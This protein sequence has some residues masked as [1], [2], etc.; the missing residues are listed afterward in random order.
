MVMTIKEVYDSYKKFIVAIYIY[1]E[2]EMVGSGTGFLLSSGHLITNF[3]IF[4]N[5][6]INL[7]NGKNCKVKLV[8]NEIAVEIH[9]EDIKKIRTE[10]CSMENNNDYIILN[11][12]GHV[13]K[14][15]YESACLCFADEE[16]VVGQRCCILGYP[17]GKNRLSIHECMVSSIYRKC[18][19]NVYQLDGSVNTGNSGGPLVDVATGRII[20][21]V[22]RK[23]NGLNELFN[24]LK[25]AMKKNCEIM[26]GLSD[27]HIAIG[28]FD[29]VQAIRASLDNINA[30][31]PHI[32]RSAN[33]GIGY[34][35]EIK[36]IKKDISLV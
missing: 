14:E 15:C 26:Q 21:I 34:A 13:N 23:E 19:I 28:G 31:I 17:F 24:E 4:E 32:E 22:S 11:I 20:G 3:H 27:Y 10:Y 9:N 35:F 29:A 1:I 12:S 5:L 36:Q 6:L 7:N 33:V 18:E 25:Q 2:E 8:F 30:L 16:P